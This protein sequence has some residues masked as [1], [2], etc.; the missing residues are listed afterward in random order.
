[1]GNIKSGKIRGE[2]VKYPDGVGYAV[3][4]L[5]DESDEDGGNLCF[6]FSSDDIEDLKKV[7][8]ELE[9]AEPEIY[10]E[11]P[12]QKEREEKIEKKRSTW[13][14]KVWHKLKDIQV[15]IQPFN[16]GFGFD[17]MRFI[18]NDSRTFLMVSGVFRFG[19]LMIAW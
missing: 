9:V 8:E 12:E 7:I 14:Y 4:L 17:G 10:K 15:A 11:D 6:D 16:W 19:P 3:W 1:M 2:K 18:R 13:Y 5:W